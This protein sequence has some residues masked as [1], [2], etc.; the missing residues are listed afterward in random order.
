LDAVLGILRR[1]LGKEKDNR[2]GYVLRQTEAF[3]CRVKNRHVGA[4]ECG[5]KGIPLLDKA[6]VWLLAPMLVGQLTTTLHLI[7][8]DLMSPFWSLWKDSHVHVIKNTHKSL[9]KKRPI[10]SRKQM[11]KSVERYHI[12]GIFA[13]QCQL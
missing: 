1:T 3:S 9:K 6:Q 10:E 13:S 11:C 5:Q 2:D 4:G 12:M 7:L 8:C